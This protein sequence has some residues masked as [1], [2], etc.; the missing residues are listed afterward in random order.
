MTHRSTSLRAQGSAEAPRKV[1]PTENV[2]VK[3]TPGQSLGL[4]LS[5]ANVLEGAVAGSNAEAAGLGRTGRFAGWIVLRVNGVDLPRDPRIGEGW[6]CPNIDALAKDTTPAASSCPA[7][8]LTL[9]RPRK[10]RAS[11]PAAAAT[12]ATPTR[13]PLPKTAARSSSARVSPST[14]A[15]IPRGVPLRAIGS[16][17]S[18]GSIRSV[19]SS[20][21]DAG[22]TKRRQVGGGGVG[23]SLF[24]AASP[25]AA[26]PAAAKEKAKAKTKPKAKAAAA[27]GKAETRKVSRP[28]AQ[29]SAAGATTAA[30][31]RVRGG[32]S[33]PATSEPKHRRRNSDPLSFLRP[34]SG[35]GTAHKRRRS[36]GGGGGGG[37]DPGG[38]PSL[39]SSLRATASTTP[40]QAAAAAAAV[41]R[42][43][44]SKSA[45]RPPPSS[46]LARRGST[47]GGPPPRRSSSRGGGLN[48]AVLDKAAAE[49]LACEV[50][51]E[52]EEE[53]DDLPGGGGGGGSAPTASLRLA[54]S[55]SSC[56]PVI[57]RRGSSGFLRRRG[58]SSLSSSLVE[59]RSGADDAAEKALLKKI[60][61]RKKELR[62][63]LQA[64]YRRAARTCAERRRRLGAAEEE[65]QKTLRR[66][67]DLGHV[68]DVS[69]VS[70]HKLS[71][72]EGF[73]ALKERTLKVDGDLEKARA[74]SDHDAA[75]LALHAKERA[76]E[77]TLAAVSTQVVTKQQAAADGGGAG[78]GVNPRASRKKSGGGEPAE[79]D[80]AA[81][82]A[83]S[84]G[85]SPR[86]VTSAHLVTVP[87]YER[88]ENLISSVAALQRELHTLQ[89]KQAAALLTRSGVVRGL[90][91]PFFARGSARAAAA[92]PPPPATPVPYTFPADP[93]WEADRAVAWGVRA[94]ED[95]DTDDAAGSADATRM[96][97]V[98]AHWYLPPDARAAAQDGGP[99]A[100]RAGVPHP[101]SARFFE[102]L[103]TEDV[104]GRLEALCALVLDRLAAQPS[105]TGRAGVLSKNVEL[106]SWDGSPSSW[107]DRTDDG[108]DAE[109]TESEASSV[110]SHVDRTPRLSDART[111]TTYTPEEQFNLEHYVAESRRRRRASL[112]S[113][114][115]R[116]AEEAVFG[117]RPQPRAHST[118][119]LLTLGP[120]RASFSEAHHDALPAKFRGL[121]LQ[122]PQ[123]QRN[124][125]QS[126]DGDSSTNTTSNNNTNNNTSNSSGAAEP[127]PLP[128]RRAS[129]ADADSGGAVLLS[130][131]RLSGAVRNLTCAAQIPPASS[132]AA[133]SPSGEAGGS[134]SAATGRAAVSLP[135]P[136]SES[137]SGRSL[138]GTPS[139]SPS[140]QQQ[141]QQ[142]AAGRMSPRNFFHRIERHPP[143]RPKSPPRRAST[144]SPGK[145]ATSVRPSAAAAAQKKSQMHGDT[146]NLISLP[147]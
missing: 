97:P 95:D 141:Q 36:S 17:R 7:V 131:I 70:G 26:S 134:S 57:D 71:L 128:R 140:P 78:G 50:Y 144:V 77:R 18:I 16:A 24:P 23:G 113:F 41:A 11:L 3:L 107:G 73:I 87:S 115:S 32:G 53:D 147:Q 82:S 62:G 124:R 65:V 42:N 5:G 72:M 146:R 119:A 121:Q 93:A 75:F 31:P 130:P 137:G 37:G 135:P 114:S 91:D 13:A 83:G 63:L 81:A 103:G 117:P 74:A 79:S 34:L 6:A 116:E 4:Q 94:E 143:T 85:A 39:S 106:E 68:V 101:W 29:A 10:T 118:G 111:D 21:G 104:C 40:R 76:M 54:S 110:A 139:P 112:A 30:S 90:D 35:D 28:F 33:P 46:F 89:K 145:W 60:V 47:G 86:F 67:A 122:R 49:L 48:Q 102:H 2:V 22:L 66:V 105:S 127:S 19:T 123:K 69:G 96:L 58:S 100:V 51:S 88:I 126:A 12:A 55:T 38:I 27:K 9:R 8:A 129:A 120:R 25:R 44:R 108:S 98:K 133:A 15:G 138:S 61:V 1:A 132:S 59:G 56:K 136:S 45:E 14:A 43:Q 80:A 52:G 92:A 142:A 125:K 84:L 20:T 109:T 64:E 99:A